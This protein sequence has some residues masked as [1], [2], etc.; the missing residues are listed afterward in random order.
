M[1][2]TLNPQ[3]GCNGGGASGSMYSDHLQTSESPKVAKHS[4][5]HVCR[6]KSIWFRRIFKKLCLKLAYV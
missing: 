2:A 6:L 1:A 4:N 5:L 3:Q